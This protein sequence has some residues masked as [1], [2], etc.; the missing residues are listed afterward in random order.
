MKDQRLTGSFAHSKQSVTGITPL[1]KESVSKKRILVIDD[2]P[3][4]R[5]TLRQLVESLGYL[6]TETGSAQAALEL[7]ERTRFSIV[8]SDIVMPE[9]NGLEL[10]QTVKAR[11]PEVDVLIITGFERDYSALEILQ[12]GA[13]D[14]LA[15]PFGMDQLRARLHKIDRERALREKLYLRSITDDLTGLFNRRYFSQA[16]RQ[17]TERAKRQRHPLSIIMADVNEFKRFNDQKGHVEGDALLKTVAKLIQGSVREYVDLVCRYGGDEF[18]L[19]LPEIDEAK[20]AAV[21]NRIKKNFNQTSVTG[22]TLSVGVAE[23]H[24]GLDCEDRKSVV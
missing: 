20:A 12:A 19:I 9:M 3:V 5:Y 10:L 15:K 8:I 2:D 22:V 21:R 24:K 11:Y 7:M 23:L 1:R 14:F 17:E 13:S 16:L 4:F 18:V 6:C